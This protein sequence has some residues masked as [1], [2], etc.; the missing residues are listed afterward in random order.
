MKTIKLK[1]YVGF[2]TFVELQ[3]YIKRE[4][5]NMPKPKITNHGYSEQYKHYFDV[6]V[7]E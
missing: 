1:R 7:E 4:F 2:N 6:E 5:D 3:E